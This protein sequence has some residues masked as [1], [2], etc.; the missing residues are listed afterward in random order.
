MVLMPNYKTGRLYLF[1]PFVYAKGTFG[2]RF[3]H[4]CVYV[5]CIFLRSQVTIQG[6]HNV[7]SY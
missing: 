7:M 5:Q 2:L 1:L 3:I 6:V 4:N